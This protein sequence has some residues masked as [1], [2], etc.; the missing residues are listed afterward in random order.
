MPEFQTEYSVS[1]NDC[2]KAM[3]IRL[4]FSD[5]ADFSKM[6]STP[7][8]IDE[9]LHKTY[10]KLDKNGTEAAAVTAISMEKA[11]AMPRVMEKKY[12]YL[13]RPF[14]Y[15]IVSKKQLVPLFIGCVNTL[16]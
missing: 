1:L 12:V 4:A 10:I 5:L 15:A 14:V 13:D 6:S 11:S 3:G 16:A 9:V 8:K 2:L 7:L